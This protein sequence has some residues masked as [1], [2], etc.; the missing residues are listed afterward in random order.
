MERDA[1]AF[2]G[3]VAGDELALGVA[4]VQ[5]LARGVAVQRLGHV[6]DGLL[7]DLGRGDHLRVDRDGLHFRQVLV[8]IG[9]NDVG[10]EELLLGAQRVDLGAHQ[11]HQ[12][13]VAP[14]RP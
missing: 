10:R 14:R 11:R 13:D 2:D 7:R 4:R 6:V 8:G 3:V 9:G 1:R 12:F 5:R